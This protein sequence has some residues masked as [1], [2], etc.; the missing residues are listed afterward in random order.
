MKNCLTLLLGGLLGQA[1]SA[2]C[3]STQEAMAD[4]LTQPGAS[5]WLAALA[6]MAAIV[7]RRQDH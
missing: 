7:W 5:V 2:Q 1:A 4:T 6:L 3:L